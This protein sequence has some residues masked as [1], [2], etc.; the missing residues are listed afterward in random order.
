MRDEIGVSSVTGRIAYQLPTLS[1]RFMI[2][3]I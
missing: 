1:V 2:A 3:S